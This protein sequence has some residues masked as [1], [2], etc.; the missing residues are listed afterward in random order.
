[1][2]FWDSSAVVPLIIS[3]RHSEAMRQ[4]LDADRGMIVWWATA[5]ECVAAI[6]RQEREGFLTAEKINDVGDALRELRT[7]WREVP[8]STRLRDLAMRLLRSY[9]LRAADALQLAAALVAAE[10]RPDT[11]GFVCLD[12][13]LAL[14]ASREGFT[15]V[16]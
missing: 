3:L 7:R 4:L 10:E 12:D 14:A 1:V 13:R 8:P 5:V 2:R 11:L 9:P 6:A 15:V 16:A